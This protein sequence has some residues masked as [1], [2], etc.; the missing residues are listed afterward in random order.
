MS[1]AAE[2]HAK[3]NVIWQGDRLLAVVNIYGDAGLKEG[4]DNARE[5]ARHFASAFDLYEAVNV[6]VD[7]IEDHAVKPAEIY[8][9]AQARL[10]LKKYEVGE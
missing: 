7:W 6:L 9:L 8:E 5:L 3:E 2:I 10:A 4:A 1:A